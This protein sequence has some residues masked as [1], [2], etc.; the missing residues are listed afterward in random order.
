MQMRSRLLTLGLLSALV[1][2]GCK[3][4]QGAYVPPPPP[5]VTVAKP[6]LKAV[7]QTLEFTGRT[8]GIEAVEVRARVKG[9]LQR[10]LVEGG[11]RVKAGDLLFEIDPRTF[12]AAVNQSKAD[13][14]VYE[15]QLRLAEVT[16]Q[17]TQ[18]AAAGNAISK[19]EVD[20]AIAERDAA[21]AQVDLAKARLAA[22]QLDLEFTQLRAPITGRLG[23]V[24]ISEGELVGA[25]DATLITTVINDSRV[26]ASYDMTE[27]Q[28]LEQRRLNNN[29][30][31]DEDGRESLV[32]R[33]G[34]SNEIGYPHVGK[35]DRADNSVDTGTGTV[36][37][38]AIF[39]NPD[40][41][42]LPGSYV[43]IQAVLGER[44]SLLVPDVAVMSDQ[45]SRYVYVVGADGTVARRNVTAGPVIDR[46]RR[47]D[48]GLTADDT[49][50]INGV[51]RARPGAKVNA[52]AEKPAA[53]PATTTPAATATP[54]KG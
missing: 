47:I 51:Q 34:L 22:A 3:K 21:A 24:T 19:Q 33:L 39:D 6:L 17:R 50:I 1:L 31:P 26:Y 16:V 45:T 25:T 52:V 48:D 49:V 20:R 32:I 36:R 53:A 8:R 29:K 23:I 42:I 38:E 14:A 54:A 15:A 40:G 7:P 35:F 12:Q 27:M 18:A 9:F 30:R 10:K 4:Q 44:E 28:V 43:R 41:T 13:V 46:L 5:E 2:G 11:R 37:I